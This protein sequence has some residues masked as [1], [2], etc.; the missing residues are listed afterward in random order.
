MLSQHSVIEQLLFIVFISFLS[1][2]VPAV[3]LAASAVY[4]SAQKEFV[5]GN[6]DKVVAIL[7]GKTDVD[8]VILVGRARHLLDDAD[9]KPLVSLLAKEPNNE[10]LQTAMAY[11]NEESRHYREAEQLVDRIFRVSHQNA[12]AIAILALCKI[13]Q[14]NEGTGLKILSDALKL[15]DKDLIV[16]ELAEGGYDCVFDSAK[17]EKTCDRL[18]ELQPRNPYYWSMKGRF[19]ERA[20]KS[21]KALECY[22]K[23]VTVNPRF[24]FAYT[25]RA[26]MYFE[27]KDYQKVVN[28]ASACIATRM[29]KGQVLDCLSLR[30]TAYAVLGKHL[31]AIADLKE[32]LKLTDSAHHPEFVK[33]DEA[34]LKM[35]LEYIALGKYSEAESVLA[36]LK[37]LNR[38]NSEVLEQEAMIQA[39]QG[40]KE[41]AI[42]M[43][44]KLIAEDGNYPTWVAAL[45]KLKGK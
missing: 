6:Y 17:T 4:Q 34:Y 35:G 21:D 32:Y 19:L 11:I 38:R 22:S 26:K 3:S 40:H 30:A 23:A 37:K 43:Y 39:R 28:D 24:E 31:E 15:N 5:L 7:K 29:A 27:R 25:S 12:Q 8:S 2:F 16:L 42:K 18:I 13:R 14:G 9:D 36:I 10:K 41:V 20:G 44:E 45:K 33:Q 1:I